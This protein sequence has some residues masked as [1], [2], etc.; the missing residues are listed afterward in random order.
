MWHGRLF[1]KNDSQPS[2]DGDL[3][4][5]TNPIS[6]QSHQRPIPIRFEYSTTQLQEKVAELNEQGRS[7]VYSSFLKTEH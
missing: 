6:V 3:I 4:T 1:G 5:P 7:P 2:L